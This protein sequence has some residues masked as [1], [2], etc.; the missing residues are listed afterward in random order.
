MGAGSSSHAFSDH[1]AIDHAAI[2]NLIKSAKFEPS[3]KDEQC[4]EMKE[5]QL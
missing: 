3:S 4:T 1:A 5:P 2:F